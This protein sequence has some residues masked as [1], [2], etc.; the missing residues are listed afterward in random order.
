[1]ALWQHAGYGQPVEE[2]M[3]I[4]QFTVLKLTM[5]EVL[6]WPRSIASMLPQSHCGDE[7]GGRNWIVF[8]PSL[9]MYYALCFVHAQHSVSYEPISVL[10][11]IFMVLALCLLSTLFVLTLRIPE[12]RHWPT[13]ARV[14]PQSHSGDEV[15]RRTRLHS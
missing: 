10:I 13:I 15:D 8:M 7:E 1:M 5:C 3:Q 14:S 6:Q 9:Y 2:F 12:L 11:N 4:I